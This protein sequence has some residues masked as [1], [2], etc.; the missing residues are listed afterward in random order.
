MRPSYIY[1]FLGS[2]IV[3]GGIYFNTGDKEKDATERF[4]RRLSM[5]SRGY[6]RVFAS[7]DQ[8]PA[9]PERI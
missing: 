3:L 5:E 2:Q 6:D 9:R 4:L 7:S 1:G 8:F